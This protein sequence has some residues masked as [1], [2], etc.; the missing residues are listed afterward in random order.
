MYSYGLKIKDEQGTYNPACAIMTAIPSERI[1]LV[2][3]TA[4]VPYNKI[5][6]G[7]SLLPI[8]MLFETYSS[9]SWDNC[10]I[11]QC[12]KLDAF[13]NDLSALSSIIGLQ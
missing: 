3:P 13:T 6:S 7:L 12:R 9:S 8:E 2:L 10:S 11:I 4:F 1:R 5:P